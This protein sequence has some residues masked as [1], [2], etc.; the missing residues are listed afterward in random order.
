MHNDTG[1]RKW[2]VG[3]LAATMTGIALLAAACGAS[4]HTATPTAAGD[5]A[6]HQTALAFA[7]C[8]RTHGEPGWPDPTRQGNFN[9][10]KID[11]S[12][13]RY[14]RSSIACAFLRPA[15]IKILESAAQQSEVRKRLLRFARCMHS[16]GYSNFLGL[17]HGKGRHSSS[18]D[19]G[20]ASSPFFRSAMKSCGAVRYPGGWWVSG[21]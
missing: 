18:A 10:S 21:T 16:H 20:I 4:S 3:F 12:S 15:K 14:M 2:R 11:I 17:N 1:G 13:P 5:P 19:A 7:R 8:M 6:T 9:E